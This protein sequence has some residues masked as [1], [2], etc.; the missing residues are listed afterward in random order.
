M[1]GDNEPSNNS[2]PHLEEPI[3]KDCDEIKSRGAGI[4]LDLANQ[5]WNAK[6]SGN[7]LYCTSGTRFKSLKALW[8]LYSPKIHWKNLLHDLKRL[9][10]DD[11]FA[12]LRYTLLWFILFHNSVAWIWNVHS[13][14]MKA[15]DL[16]LGILKESSHVAMDSPLQLVKVSHTILPTSRTQHLIFWRILFDIQ[17]RTENG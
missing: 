11:L 2:R 16:I 9:N 1:R 17:C 5:P 10:Y 4:P 7:S 14:Y 3:W 6:K 12:F 15:K 8:I 13:F